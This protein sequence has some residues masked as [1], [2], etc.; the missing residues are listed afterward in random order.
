MLQVRSRTIFRWS[1]T[2]SAR[3]WSVQMVNTIDIKQRAGQAMDFAF[4]AWK[5]LW[6]WQTGT[7]KGFRTTGSSPHPTAK[8]RGG[9]N[10][11]VQWTM[12]TRKD[13]IGF[14]LWNSP[15]GVRNGHKSWIYNLFQLSHQ[16]FVCFGQNIICGCVQVSVT[17]LV[18]CEA[19]SQQVANLKCP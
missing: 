13:L 18:L 7:T 11:S 10:V 17:K 14:L 19:T 9:G 6:V 15:Q 12:R 2:S 16:G 3:K 1:I 5:H 8:K 4:S